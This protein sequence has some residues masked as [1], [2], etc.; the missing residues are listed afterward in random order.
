MNNTMDIVT[1]YGIGPDFFEYI[2]SHKSC[3]TAKLLLASKKPCPAFDLKFAILQIECRK[4]ISRKVPELAGMPHFIFPSALSTEQ[5][6]CQ[7][8]A[9]FHASLLDGCANVLDLTAGLGIDDYYIA[10]K[11]GHLTAVEKNPLTAS[12][13][14]YNMAMYR[15]GMTVVND[16]AAS[17]LASVIASHARFDAVFIDPARRDGQDKRTYGLSDCEPDVMQMLDGIREITDTLYIKASPMLDITLLTTT[18]PHLAAIHIVGVDN[19]CKELLLKLDFKTTGQEGGGTCVNTLN[20]E[21]GSDAPQQLAFN[22][23]E[24]KTFAVNY[25]SE[26]LAYLYEPNC[27]IMKGGAFPALAK[28]CPGLLKL[29]QNTH[30]FT[31]AEPRYGFPGRAFRVVETIPFKDKHIKQLHKQYPKANISTRNFRLPAHEV[32]KKLRIADGGDT[33]IFATTLPGDRQVLVITNK[34]I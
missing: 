3:D 33:Y 4:R 2:E 32:K 7:P 15:P 11:T 10:G 31:S 20:F 30:L 26:V 14:K 28:A 18:V 27:C 16:D 12:A 29:G 13:L 21:T 23:E 8:V 9:Q 6:T 25:G 17:Y 5:C 24:Q 1:E 22:T 34:L 19:E